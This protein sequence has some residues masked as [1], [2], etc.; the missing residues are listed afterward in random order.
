MKKVLI[1]LNIPAWLVHTKTSIIYAWNSIK[2]IVKPPRCEEC[3]ARMHAKYYHIWHHH[4][5]NGTRLLIENHGDKKMC[6]SCLV[7]EVLANDP[8]GGQ[9]GDLYEHDVQN[10]CDCCQKEDTLAYRFYETAKIRL[11]YCI[12]WWNGF[13]ICKS[14]TVEA[15]QHGVIKTGMSRMTGKHSYDIGA[16]G[17]L[18]NSKGKVMLF[19]W[20]KW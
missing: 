7:K 1:V 15:L 17:L 3:G 13:H 12:Q 18:L 11:H 9:Y 10:V 19:K 8:S 14:C 5:E 16:N 2:W 20:C 6:P 4:K